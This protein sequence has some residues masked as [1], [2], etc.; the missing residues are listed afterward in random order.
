MT[1]VLRRLLVLVLLAVVP[2]L[3]FAQTGRADRLSQLENAKIAYLTDK[4]SLTQDQAQK[5]WPVYNDFTTKRRDLNRRMRQLRIASP[6][7]L[8]DQ[9]I[10]ENLTQALALRQQEV[11]L[12]TDY[13]EKFQKVLSIRQVGQLYAAER[14]FT[15]EVIKRV[16]D[17]RGG[18]TPAPRT[19]D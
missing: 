15:R 12:E 7:A 1:Y 3:S 17:R 16:A 11:K 18:R 13:F 2:A 9:Q 19:D 6:E 4:I 5:F 14:D 8:T 10:R